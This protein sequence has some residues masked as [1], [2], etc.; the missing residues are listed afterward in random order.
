MI[1]YAYIQILKT[2]TLTG[3]YKY[4]DLKKRMEEK[5]G[6]SLEFGF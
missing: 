5:S 2:P 6:R 1:L 3:N 4:R